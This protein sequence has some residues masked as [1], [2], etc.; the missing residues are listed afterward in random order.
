MKK[1]DQQTEAKKMQVH[2]F[3]NSIFLFCIQHR[4]P[5]GNRRVEN[6]FGALSL[7]HFLMMY[8]VQDC[9]CSKDYRPTLGCCWVSAGPAITNTGPVY[10]AGMMQVLHVYLPLDLDQPDHFIFSK[11][12][13]LE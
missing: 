1:T 12:L 6:P 2:E 13:I 9:Y 8:I 4:V 3:L 10:M 11:H 5:A 7:E